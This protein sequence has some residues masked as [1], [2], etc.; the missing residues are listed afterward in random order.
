MNTR[1][2]TPSVSESFNCRY[3]DCGALAHQT[4]FEIDMRRYDDNR[5]PFHDIRF[6]FEEQVDSLDGLDFNRKAQLKEHLKQ[7]SSGRILPS[8]SAENSIYSRRLFNLDVSQCY[9]CKKFSVATSILARNSVT[10]T[11]S[12]DAAGV[13]C[14]QS[15]IRRG[16]RQ[17]LGQHR[18]AIMGPKSPVWCRH[19]VT[20]WR[21]RAKLLFIAGR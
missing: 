20:T 13:G 4:W 9:S 14:L 7:I 11:V 6:D 12:A 19:S 3:S 18:S 21:K 17:P 2:I 10:S 8:E 5:L 15:T 1:Y 16:G